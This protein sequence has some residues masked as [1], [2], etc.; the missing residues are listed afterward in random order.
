[1]TENVVDAIGLFCPEPI[2]RLGK[3][4]KKID[5]GSTLILLAD[6]TSAKS[7]ITSWAE[8]SGN[9]LVSTTEKDDH[10]EFLIRR[11]V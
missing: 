3:A 8:I 6:D 5:I 2:V 10:I 7:D 11:M 1:M 9:E 4:I